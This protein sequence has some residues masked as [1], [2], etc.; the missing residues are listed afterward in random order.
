MKSSSIMPQTVPHALDPFLRVETNT[1]FVVAQTE[2]GKQVRHRR[3][4]KW[5]ALAVCEFDLNAQSQHRDWETHAICC[6]G[7]LACKNRFLPDSQQP[8]SAY[9]VRGEVDQEEERGK[10]VLMVQTFG[11]IWGI[12]NQD[13]W[14]RRSRHEEGDVWVRNSW[15]ALLNMILTNPGSS[16]LSPDLLSD[17]LND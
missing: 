7:A 11:R 16:P 4:W 17:T 12:T 10:G 1:C 8:L 15:V 3:V 13:W 14:K 9:I 2:K 6:C 5:N